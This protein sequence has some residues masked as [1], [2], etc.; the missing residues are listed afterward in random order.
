MAEVVKVKRDG[1]VA[2]VSLNRPEKLNAMSPE[3]FE[4][5]LEAGGEVSSDDAVRAVVVRGEGRAF[6]SGL[7]LS[8]LSGFGGGDGGGGRTSTAAVHRGIPGAQESFNVWARM[9][10]PVVA[11]VQGYAL[12]AGLQLALACDI[13]ICAEGATWSVFEITYGLIPDLG[14]TQRLPRLV[15]EGRAKELIW[16][17]RRFDAREAEAWGIA[18]RV[19]APEQLDKEVLELAA[20]LGSRPP[21]PIR[22]TKELVSAPGPCPPRRGCAARRSIRRCA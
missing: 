3:V 12:G 11:A 18:N 1:A 10:K 13:R 16:T 4:G 14:A 21:L 6:S 9:P 22:Y 7:D 17:A 19:V 2:V 15:G 8:S 20:D 5:L